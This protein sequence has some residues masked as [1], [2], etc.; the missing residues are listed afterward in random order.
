MKSHPLSLVFGIFM[1]LQIIDNQQLTPLKGMT[2]IQVISENTQRFAGLNFIYESEDYQKLLELCG[3]EL[4][5]R[6]TRGGGYTYPE[7]FNMLFLSILAGATCIEDVNLLAPELAQHPFMKTPKAD[8]VLRTFNR[9]AVENEVVT[10]RRCMRYKFNRN[11]QLNSLL[12]KGTVALGLLDKRRKC[13]FD[14][15]NQIIATEKQD[16]LWTYKEVK[17]YAPGVAFANGHPIH[18]EGRDGN[19]GVVFDQAKTLTYAYEALLKEGIKVRRS[20]MDAGSYSK[21]VVSVV[22]EYSD[23]FYI[24][25]KQTP[26][27]TSLVN[28]STRGWRRIK[29][30]TSKGDLREIEVRSVEADEFI[31]GKTYRVVLYRYDDHWADK[32]MYKD[33]EAVKYRHF[34]II[35]NDFESSEEEIVKY[36][37]KRGAIERVFD[38]LNND[39]NWA[40]LPCSDMNHNVVFMILTALLRNFYTKYV[41]DLSR[42]TG[43]LIH[44]RSRI[45]AFIFHFVTGPAQWVKG[46]TGYVLRLFGLTPL[47]RRFVERMYAT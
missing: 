39:F 28:E 5:V 4:G 33:D 7:V 20:R 45:K 31:K 37:N 6:S 38:Q 22:E 9:L 14:Y 16:A 46:K 1:V 2:K 18:V 8:T 34:G 47:Q 27:Y 29:L 23:L 26:Y 32:T 21:E 43:N 24:R 19:A 10:S 41:A 40:H 25:S 30:R 11:H 15:D 42:S 13:D 36:Y 17:G 12:V 44:R 3:R 35:T